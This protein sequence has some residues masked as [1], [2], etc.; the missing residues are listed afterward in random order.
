MM[1][2]LR[3]GVNS[4]AVKII[5]GLIILSFVLAGVSNYLFTGSNNG[6]ADVG[7]TKISHSE[8]EQAYQN[9]R[10]R[11]QAQLGDYFSNL[12]A[13]SSYVASFRRS[14]LDRMVNDL[15]LQQHAQSLGL[16][17]SDAQVRQAILDTAEFQSDGKFN[18]D[19]YNNAL[20]RAGFTPDSFAAYLRTDLVRSQLMAAVQT[21]DFSLPGEVAAQSKLIAQ[22][23]NVKTI[24][25]KQDEFAK[26]AS[27]SDDEIKAYY[28]QHSDSFT[29]PEQFK[30]SYIELDAKALEVQME[31]AD[32]D[33]QKFYQ[34]HLDKYSSA[35][36]RDVSHIL[37]QDDE[38]KAQDLLAKIRAGGD[39]AE[40]AKTQSQDSG[41][42][43][44]GGELG[45][46]EKGT[47]DP[48][49]EK[50]AFDLKEIGSVS[51]V[52][53]SN[54][55]YHI[56]KL[57]DIKSASAKPFETVRN[58]VIAQIKSEKALD[59][60]YA[61]QTDL[62]KVAFESPD[63]LDESAKAIS[64]EVKHTDFI[65][66]VDAPNL[67]QSPAVVQA[68]NS[69]EVKHDG[70]NSQVLEVAPEHVIVVRVDETRK[71]MVL[72][73]DEVKDQVK[74]QLANV[75]GAAKANELAGE[76][77]SALKS[78]DQSVLSANNLTFGELETIS[79]NSP[80]ANAIFSMKKP[81][82]GTSVFGQ[83]QDADGNVV[84]V[85]LLTVEA[86]IKPEL[87]KQ[88]G[89]QLE[90]LDRQ[91]DVAGI[92]SILRANTDIKYYLATE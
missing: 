92:L 6:A 15:L 62:E 47:M 85:E 3:E 27:L 46:I 21:S 10:N 52:V 54:F 43:E 90:R 72:P 40:L 81:L 19:I 73:L 53:K 63:S 79:R 22:T 86:N 42:A 80:L 91:Q 74:S 31:V 44:E 77:V 8:F 66:Q 35:E 48:A 76:L 32:A 25:L 38:Q 75:K 89:A 29:R 37:V 87:S 9:E 83:T 55:G 84:I 18:Q 78:G 14:V 65:S 11:M 28:D 50:A 59:R 56:I 36:Q 12:L 34:E 51:E 20:R 69:D 23:R 17:V 33:A 61:L 41:S 57:N 5:L 58:D 1:D 7:G 64:V 4:I 71:A 30:I 49:F 67:L 26:A 2:R 16:A 68:L 60:F 70:L 82:D 88:V 39:F 24:T 45:L 13:D